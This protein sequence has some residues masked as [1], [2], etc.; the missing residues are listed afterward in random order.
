[1]KKTILGLMASLVVL[2]AVAGEHGEWLTDLP[3]AQA[4]AKEEK[5][6]VLMDFTGSD[7][8][9][10]CK[11]L[12]KNVLSTSTFNEFAGKN[13]VLVELDF[14]RAK[15]QEAELKKANQA[16]QAKYD[17]EGYPTLVLLNPEGKEVWRN[18]G[19]SGE[20]PKDMVAKIEAA[21]KKPGSSSAN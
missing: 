20:A 10:P 5:K 13:L 18:V 21:M 8:C 9:P 14:P 7:W 4:K 6:F 12:H 16:L 2:T 15:K 17:I 3:K 19:Y 11:A 1:M